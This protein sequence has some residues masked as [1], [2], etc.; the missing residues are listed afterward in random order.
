MIEPVVPET[1]RGVQAASATMTGL[2][3]HAG[4]P[5]ETD[6]GVFDLA[7]LRFD[8]EEYVDDFNRTVVGGY[9]AGTADRGLPADLD[10]ARSVIARHRRGSRLL[11]PCAATS[12]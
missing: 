1:S 9:R 8:V 7:A 11:E 4:E 5:K 6:V 10:V 3:K 2:G 12:G